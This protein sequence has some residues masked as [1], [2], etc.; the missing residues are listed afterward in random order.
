MKKSF[1]FTSLL[2]STA[3]FVTTGCSIVTN[4]KVKE[5]AISIK[6]D[7]AK[8]LDVELNLGAGEMTVK[9]GT[10]NWV[11][12]SILYNDKN[13]KPKVSYDL[14]GSRGKVRITQS[15]KGFS[16][17]KIG[18]K[19]NEWNLELTNKVPLNL[20]VNT[21]ASKTNLNLNGLNLNKLDIE[22]GVGE[23]DVDLSGNWKESFDTTI[24]TGVGKTTVILPSD[25][26]VKV[27][28]SKG[29]GKAN[30]IDLISKGNGV[31][32]NEA[33]KDAKVIL[34]VNMEL[35]VGEVNFKLD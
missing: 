4:G 25:I 2:I 1:F 6:K 15:D 28:S 21:G 7:K 11:E 18:K 20:E 19:T 32:V 5:E 8:E 23:L 3:L 33:Y 10:K 22:T 13:L 26:G 24:E 27:I 16:N 9:K 30:V 14:K 29:I 34:T 35:G 12:G 31:Y 17:V